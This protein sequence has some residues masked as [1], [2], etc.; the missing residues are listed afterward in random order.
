[1]A[2]RRATLLR[3]V[4]V[5]F[6]RRFNGVAKIADDA[7]EGGLL[8]GGQL[9]FAGRA[10]YDGALSSKSGPCLC[11]SERVQKLEAQKK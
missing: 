7:D 9:Q 2:Q 11:L 4:A 5:F 1:M 3:V 8:I 10:L 6:R